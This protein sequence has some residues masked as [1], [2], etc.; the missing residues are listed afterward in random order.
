MPKTEGDRCQSRCRKLCTT[1]LASLDPVCQLPFPLIRRTRTAKRF[2][3]MLPSDLIQSFD[4]PLV[5][6]S[7]V[8]AMLIDDLRSVLAPLLGLLI[9]SSI[10]HVSSPLCPDSDCAPNTPVAARRRVAVITL[11]VERLAQV[12]AMFKV[13]VP[14][15]PTKFLHRH[16]MVCMCG[17]VVYARLLAF[18]GP[19]EQSTHGAEVGSMSLWTNVAVVVYRSSRNSCARC[20]DTTTVQSVD[21]TFS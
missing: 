1:A 14:S 12:V 3:P 10:A 8:E 6:E 15:Y 7:A 11:I 17:V 20:V 19:V 13:A 5:G 4:N 18:V 16:H 2:Q 9:E 21:A